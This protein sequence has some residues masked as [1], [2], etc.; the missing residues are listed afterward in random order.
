M[1][2]KSERMMEIEDSVY[3]M[4]AAAWK[5]AHEGVKQTRDEADKDYHENFNKLVEEAL[6]SDNEYQ[7]LVKEE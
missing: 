7:A 3:D 2:T 1:N 5:L 4:V 6:K